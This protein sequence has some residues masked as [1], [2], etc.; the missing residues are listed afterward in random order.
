MRYRHRRQNGDGFQ[1]ARSLCAETTIFLWQLP[2]KDIVSSRG[3]IFPST[4]LSKSFASKTCPACITNWKL[5]ASSMCSSRFPT[6]TRRLAHL[7]AS[8]ELNLSPTPSALAPLMVAAFGAA[9]GGM[10]A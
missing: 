7:P 2:S 6:A 1:D 4:D 5:R 10:P 9:T 3:P 8:M